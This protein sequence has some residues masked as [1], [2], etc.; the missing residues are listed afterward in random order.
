MPGKPTDAD[1]GLTEKDWDTLL[2]MINRSKCTPF[3]GAGVNHGILPLGPELANK[4]AEKFGYPFKDCEDLSRV[5]QFV[6]IDRDPLFVKLAVLDL[7]A[8]ELKQRNISEL[9][10]DPEQPLNILASAPTT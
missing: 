3:L 2:Y 1:R 7:L 8:E 9:L 4:L 10:G 5:A 6:A